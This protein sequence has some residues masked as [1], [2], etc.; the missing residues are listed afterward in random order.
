MSKRRSEHEVDPKV[1]S[2]NSKNVLAATTRHLSAYLRVLCEKKEKKTT[3]KNKTKQKRKEQ[4]K[5]KNKN[6]NNK[7]QNKTK[8]NKNCNGA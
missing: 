7:K 4:Q 6:N 1:I 2:I 8:Q 3:T 5:T